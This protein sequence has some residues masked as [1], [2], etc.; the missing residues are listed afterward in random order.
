MS[1]LLQRQID[2]A[3]QNVQVR[4]RYSRDIL[5]VVDGSMTLAEQVEKN[6]YDTET[7]KMRQDCIIAMQWL[8]NCRR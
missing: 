8:E 2:D 1:T 7:L 5:T 3:M 4:E 6:E